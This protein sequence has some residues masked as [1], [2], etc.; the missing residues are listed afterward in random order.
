MEPISNSS[1]IWDVVESKNYYI[2]KTDKS[3]FETL[4]Y[5]I[6]KVLN[7]AQKLHNLLCNLNCGELSLP[8]RCVWGN[9]H[10]PD[11]KT[12]PYQTSE[13]AAGTKVL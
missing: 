8:R 12:L 9:K 13:A 2:I 11:M 3:K 6:D 10:A 7:L 1:L 5:T 4:Q